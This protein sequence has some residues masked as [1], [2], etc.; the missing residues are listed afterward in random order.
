M[1]STN[2]ASRCSVAK[3]CTASLRRAAF[4]TAGAGV[5][6]AG[7]SVAG[8]GNLTV[9]AGTKSMRGYVLGC[10]GSRAPTDTTATNRIGWTKPVPTT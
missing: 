6:S 8:A 5:G 1:K 7:V 10:F 2:R 4:G 3:S 9:L